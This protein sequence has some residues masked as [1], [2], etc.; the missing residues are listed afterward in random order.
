MN[1]MFQKAYALS[2][3]NKLLTRCAWAG[4]SVFGSAYGSWWGPGNCE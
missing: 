4:N 1:S 3:A 2:D